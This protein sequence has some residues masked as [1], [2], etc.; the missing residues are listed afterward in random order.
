MILSKKSFRSMPTWTM[1][2]HTLA[3]QN[4]SK[5]KLHKALVATLGWA[6]LHLRPTKADNRL[7]FV[8]MYLTLDLRIFPLWP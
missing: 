2:S 5:R 4:P 3:C 8:G 1:M 7:K 6:Q